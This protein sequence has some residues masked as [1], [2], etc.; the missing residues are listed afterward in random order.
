MAFKTS[1]PAI[2]VQPSASITPVSIDPPPGSIFLCYRRDDS[3]DVTGRIYDRLQHVFTGGAVFRDVDSIPFGVDFREHVKAALAGCGVTL[4]VIGKNWLDMKDE[5]GA[6]R[7]EDPGDFVRLEIETALAKPGMR[8]IPVLVGGA[9]LPHPTDLPESLRP[10]RYRNGTEVRRDP[11]FGRD[12]DRLLAQ[13]NDALSVSANSSNKAKGGTSKR[14]AVRCASAHS[15]SGVGLGKPVGLSGFGVAAKVAVLLFSVGAII[16]I[17]MLLASGQRSDNE[18]S[19]DAGKRSQ[20]PELS[21]SSQNDQQSKPAGQNQDT[22][23][24][25]EDVS[26][27]I[28]TRRPRDRTI[29]PTVPDQP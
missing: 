23:A 17:I 5:S 15:D 2:L 13:I 9:R 29:K 28:L 20:T 3:A 12:M 26:G 6:R 7:L 10:L 14:E 4:V 11:D 27:A 1:F 25:E 8:V 19:S 18:A 22:K 24:S 21:N 16:C